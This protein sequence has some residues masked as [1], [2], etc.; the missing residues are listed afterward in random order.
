MFTLTVDAW[1]QA[2][3]YLIFFMLFYSHGSMF[4]FLFTRN[5][6]HLQFRTH[7]RVHTGIQHNMRPLLPKSEIDQLVFNQVLYRVVH[8][9]FSSFCLNHNM[10][11]FV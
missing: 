8:F 10:E 3:T 2:Y 1:P 7:T 9:V 5:A 11:P 4:I 6:L